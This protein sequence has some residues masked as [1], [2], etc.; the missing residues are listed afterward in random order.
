MPWRSGP[1]ARHGTA[2]SSRELSTSHHSMPQ[3]VPQADPQQT[4]RRR[5]GRQRDAAARL[6]RG[7]GTC[8]MEMPTSS[9]CRLVSSLCSSSLVAAST[10]MSLAVAWCSSLMALP[11]GPTRKAPA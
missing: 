5:G 6:L 1:A 10:P 4:T 7:G 9:C 3:E 2:G 8:M 11:R